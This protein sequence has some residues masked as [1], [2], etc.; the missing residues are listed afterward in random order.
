MTFL[1]KSILLTASILLTQ[2]QIVDAQASPAITEMRWSETMRSVSPNGSWQ[3]E[4]APQGEDGPGLVLVQKAAGGERHILLRLQRDGSVLW[5]PDSKS[6]II[7]DRAFSDHYRL[8]LF[9]VP[10]PS[11]G[12]QK[13]LSLDRMVQAAVKKSMNPSEEINYYLP[14]VIGWRDGD[15]LVAVGVTAVRGDSGP[16]IPHCFGYLADDKTLSIT[17]SLSEAELKV[18]FGAT[19]QMWP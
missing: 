3:L 14:K 18:G 1:L 6:L 17:R 2:T 7:E 5:S 10:F 9:H 16:F 12:Q 19:C 8:M 11:Q 4:V 13:A 15:W